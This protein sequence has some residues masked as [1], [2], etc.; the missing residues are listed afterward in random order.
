MRPF[1]SLLLVACFLVTGLLVVCLPAGSALAV[2]TIPAAPVPE[3][4]PY[5]D[6]AVARQHRYLE[7][8]TKV[9]LMEMFATQEAERTANQEQYDVTFYDLIMDVESSTETLVGITT[10]EAVVLAGPLS[11]MELNLQENMTVS[12]TTCA[13]QEVSHNHADNLLTVNLDRPYDEGEEISV[14]VTYAGAP[15]SDSFG[16]SSYGGAPLVWTLSEPYGARNWWPCKDLNTDKADSVALHVTVDDNL[17]V[18]SNGLLEQET[19]PAPGKRTYH[20]RTRY[21]IPTYLVSLAIHPYAVFSDEYTGLD[22]ETTMPVDNYVIPAYQGQASVGYAPTVAMITAFAQAFGEYPFIEEKYGHAHFPWGGGMEHQTLSSMTYEFYGAYLVAHELAHQW[23]GDMITCADFSHI[24]LNEGFATWCEAYWQEVHNGPEA[25]REEM[26]DAAYYGP[27]TVFVEDPEDFY[28]IFDYSLTYQKASW[29][30][31]MLRGQLGDE[32]FFA[33]LRLYR[34][35]YR[36]G[37]ATTEQFQEM[38]EQASGRDLTPFIQQWIYGSGH[39]YYQV[40]WNTNPVPGGTHVQVRIEQLQLGQV[41]DMAI[42]LRLEAL[43]GGERV[44]VENNRRVQY[45]DFTVTGSVS[46]V[47]LDPDDWILCEVTYGGISDVPLAAA[48]APRL[49][50]NVPNPF[51]PS[52]DVR[53]ELPAAADVTMGVYDISGRLVR[54]LLAG[55]NHAA[56]VHSVR[57]DGR[58]TAGRAQASG[59]YFVRMNAGGEW[60]LRKITLVQ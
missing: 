11:T 28:D 44:R 46:G 25:Y 2:N 36:Y 51:N 17:I 5:T 38:M 18:A 19:V 37:S 52:T 39:P 21:P 48:G 10:I 4:I 33:G 59:T 60:G 50:A 43:L 47:V 56:G 30:V 42:D 22:G 13:G 6:E 16:W 1:V 41:F 29:V 54:T 23:W 31:H 12:T 14:T 8:M 32:D 7:S 58:D 24:W 9:R 49:L 55:E 20:W 34:E 45:Y 26:A 35:N 27:G 3:G 53:F 57:W 40:N 15:S